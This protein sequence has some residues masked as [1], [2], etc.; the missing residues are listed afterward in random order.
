[1]RIVIGVG[2]ASGSLYAKVMLQKLMLQ[3]EHEIQ[4]VFT[5]NAMQNWRL[6]NPEVDPMDFTFKIFDNKDFSAGFASGSGKFDAMIICPCSAGLMGRIANG[7]SDDL[8]TRSADVMLKERKKLI[9]VLRET[10]LHL[11]HIENMRQLTLAGAIICPAIPSFYSKPQTMDELALTVS[12]RALEL[13][14]ID[15]ASFQWGKS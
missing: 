10:P 6:E 7:V 2:G 11:I 3:K 12:N 1:M 8:M 13:A 4:L 5:G 14:G 15:T 9:L